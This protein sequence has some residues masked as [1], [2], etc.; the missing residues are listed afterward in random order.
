MPNPW[1]EHVKKYA[2]KNNI[3]YGCAI[4]EAGPSYRAKKEKK[5]VKAVA[6]ADR[7]DARKKETTFLKSRGYSKDDRKR[8]RSA[9][10]MLVNFK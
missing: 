10:P 4:S 5:I 9:K 8:Y 7:K 2:K 3:A 1:V 6:K